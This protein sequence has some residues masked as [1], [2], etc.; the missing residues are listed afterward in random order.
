MFSTLGNRKLEIYIRLG[1]NLDTPGSSPVGKTQENGINS[2]ISSRLLRALGFSGSKSFQETPSEEK[3]MLALDEI[4]AV[5]DQGW[6]IPSWGSDEPS[7]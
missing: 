4:Q 2:E 1:H 7:L 5:L 6:S 3:L